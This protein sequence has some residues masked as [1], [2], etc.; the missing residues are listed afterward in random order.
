MTS[1]R[2]SLTLLVL[3]G[4]AWGGLLTTAGLWL[5]LIAG[6]QSALGPWPR[7]IG[8]LTA[9]GAGLLV[10]MCLVADRLFPRASRRVVVWS[11]LL[12]SL[13]VF[14]GVVWLSALLANLLSPAA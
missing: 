2:L 11:E 9:A 10:F 13:V 1:R 4:T 14:F 7:L 6:D 12:A 5:L 3:A 8:G